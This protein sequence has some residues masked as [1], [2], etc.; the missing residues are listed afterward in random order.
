M[1]FWNVLGFHSGWYFKFSSTGHYTAV[2]LFRLCRADVD[3]AFSFSRSL[4][5]RL[6]GLLQTV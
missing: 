2:F 5:L 4:T 6:T 1:G 3:G